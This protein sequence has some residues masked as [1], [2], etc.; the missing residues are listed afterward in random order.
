MEK[1]IEENKLIAIFMGAIEVDPIGNLER[2]ISFEHPVDGLHCYNETGL[3]YH[4]SWDWLMP[5]C[6]KIRKVSSDFY[7]SG[8]DLLGHKLAMQ[9]VRPMLNELQNI[10]I[11]SVHFCA[12]KFI[13][14]HNHYINNKPNK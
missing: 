14:W 2:N 4:S 10:R 13:Q 11:D 12:V 7:T 5:V 9:R 3:K 1:E 8:D 6:M